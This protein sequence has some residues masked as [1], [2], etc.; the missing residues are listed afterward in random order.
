MLGR[1]NSDK[2]AK[3]NAMRGDGFFSGRAQGGGRA[4]GLLHVSFRQ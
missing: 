2:G 1:R 3:Q 4:E